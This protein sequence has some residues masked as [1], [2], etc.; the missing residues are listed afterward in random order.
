MKNL[1]IAMSGSILFVCLLL[2]S[3]T[4]SSKN[5]IELVRIFYLPEGLHTVIAIQDCD[6]IFQYR[7]VLR[8]TI[9]KEKQMIEELYGKCENLKAA[10]DS[11][12]HVDLRIRCTFK[13]K[14]G[15]KKVLCTGAYG[16]VVYEGVRMQDDPELLKMIKDIVYK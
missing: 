11:M 12:G 2:I 3:C 7:E 8:D 16:N 9:I 10:E 6:E 14:D 5:E 4:S 1:R 13:Y 15:S